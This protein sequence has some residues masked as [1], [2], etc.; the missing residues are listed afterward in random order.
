MNVAF[1]AVE[2]TIARGP[3]PGAAAAIGDA[4]RD[5]VACFG[6]LEPDGA[7]VT[8]ETWYD[9]ASLT[10]VLVTMP[11]CL[12]AIARGGLD[13]RAHVRDV[14]PEVA[15]LQPSPNLGDAT[16]LQLATHT[17]GLPAWEPLY[18]LG[19]DRA[20]LMARVLYTPVS[21]TPGKIVYSD[22]GVL[23]LGHIL[24]RL[25][26]CSLDI[27]ARSMFDRLGLAESL[28]YTLPPGAPVAPTE[29]CPWRGRLLRGEVHDENACALGGIAPHAGLF[30]TLR[31]VAGFAR[32]LLDGRL[33]APSVVAYLSQEHA[34]SDD[35]R[36]GFGWALMAPGWSG[37]DLMS[38]RSI[39]H[40]GFTGTGLWLDLERQ[41]FSVL[42]SNRVYPS[43]HVESGIGGLRRAFNHAA[44][45]V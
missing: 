19:L 6:R 17:S 28:A 11:L 20:T 2:Q 13:P 22:L 30:G 40:T 21:G 35:E 15:W 5:H 14:L 45:A 39:G 43:R 25:S 26:G 9:L 32:A 42:L 23:V 1:E 7:A 36:R 31:G 27:L 33:H 8:P 10:K 3:I 44:H 37:G 29:Q 16:V 4:Q 18:T 34:R 12:E 38:P 41:R 24:E